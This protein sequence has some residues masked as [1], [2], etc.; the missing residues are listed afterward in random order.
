MNS[1]PDRPRLLLPLRKGRM[2]VMS[3]LACAGF[4]LGLA[5]IKSWHDHHALLINASQSLPDWAFL[6]ETG[7]FARRGDYVV[8]S[9]GSDPLVLRHFGTPPPVFVKLALGL[10]GD[11]VSRRGADVL[12]NGRPIARLK[13]SSRQGERLLPGPLGAVPPGCVFAGSPHKDGLDSR[14]AAIGFVCQDRLIGTAE[15]IL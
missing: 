5:G 3:V 10:P 1:A 6:V 7:R 13:A 4:G 14:Y 8:F 11:I 9:P 2:R 12:I 15:A